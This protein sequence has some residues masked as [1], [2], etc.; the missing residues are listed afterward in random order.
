MENLQNTSHSSCPTAHPTDGKELTPEPT[1]RI[2][3]AQVE[4]IRLLAKAV[5][6]EFLE[7]TKQEK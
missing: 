4:L 3:T 5:A 2:A 7:Q 1:R 6:A